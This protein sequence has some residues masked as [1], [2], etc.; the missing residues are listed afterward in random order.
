MDTMIMHP[1]VTSSAGESNAGSST[2]KG[3]QQRYSNR[4][5]AVSIDF[6]DPNTTNGKSTGGIKKKHQILRN[7]Y[8][9]NSNNN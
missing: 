5:K 4:K 9:L 1:Y 8:V 6:G 7:A 2:Q 3:G